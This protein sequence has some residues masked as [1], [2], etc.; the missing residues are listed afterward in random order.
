MTTDSSRVYHSVKDTARFV[1]T[2]SISLV[3][4][5]L[6]WFIGSLPVLT[7][8]IST[9]GAYSALLSLRD[10]GSIERNTVYSS[11][12]SHWVNVTLFSWVVIIIASTTALYFYRYVVNGGMLYAIFCI[13]GIYLLIFT[14]VMGLTSFI[15]LEQ[16]HRFSDAIRNSYL[17][18]IANP[19]FSVSCLLLGAGVLVIGV[20]SIVGLVVIIP[21]LLFSFH[22]IA[23][24]NTQQD[25]ER[26]AP[27]DPQ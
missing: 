11:L 19:L 15:F 23:F 3:G 4:V 14:I 27:S 10:S 20:I 22:I 8:G 18:L 12:K 7:V 21:G 24:E 2:H 1:Y 5:S 17:L 6:L 26:L 16:N 13:L 25:M 9:L